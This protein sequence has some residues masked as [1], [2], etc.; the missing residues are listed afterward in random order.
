MLNTYSAAREAVRDTLTPFVPQTIKAAN[1]EMK[2][3]FGN[4]LSQV[5]ATGSCIYTYYILCFED[6]EWELDSFEWDFFYGDF[7]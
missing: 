1:K 6:D 7:T 2:K 3:I 5:K 4:R